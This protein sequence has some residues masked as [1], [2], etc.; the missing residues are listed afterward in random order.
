M[1]RSDRRSASIGAIPI[2]CAVL[3][4]AGSAVA[5][6][7]PPNPN[8]QRGS[9]PQ[10]PPVPLRVW[11]L[12]TAVGGGYG[13]VTGIPRCKSIPA[14]DAPCMVTLLSPSPYFLYP[15]LEARVFTRNG[16]S[17]NLSIPVVETLVKGFVGG[18][19]SFAADVFYNF[20]FGRGIVRFFV[21]PGVGF[22]MTAGVPV[23]ESARI[24]TG[25]ARLT[26]LLGV[27]FV[28]PDHHF[29]LQIRMRPWMQ[30]TFGSIGG[31][32]ANGFGGGV[33]GEVAFMGY[34]TRMSR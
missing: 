7:V 29:G 25:S 8:F 4:M 32:P 5:Q 9:Y 30:A 2:V 21:G 22:H 33:F 17:I 23:G 10:E 6:P 3:A 18:L 28:T 12:G 19:G 14:G 20:N 31:E 34:G 1:I 13:D 26:G 24:S 15:T 11:G 16:D 27:E